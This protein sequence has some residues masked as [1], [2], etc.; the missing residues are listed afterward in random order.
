MPADAE[1]PKPLV[2]HYRG[3]S[4]HKDR[5]TGEKKGTL[6]PEWTHETAEGGF[7]SDVFAHPWKATVAAALFDGAEIDAET[8]R[9]Y[10]TSRGIAFEAKPTADGSWH[11]FPVPWESVP[12]SIQAKFLEMRLV[13]RRQIKR[14]FRAERNAL[15]WALDT[16]K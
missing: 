14:F 13:T 11:G 8:G 9:R 2:P 10:A 1:N 3:S 12:R 5:P 4:K 16:D 6:C 7:E 15:Y